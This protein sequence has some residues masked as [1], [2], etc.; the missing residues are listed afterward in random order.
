MRSN[1]LINLL[2]NFHQKSFQEHQK[3][4]INQESKVKRNLSSKERARQS[5]PMVG[6]KKDYN[7]AQV[8]KLKRNIKIPIFISRIVNLDLTSRAQLELLMNLLIN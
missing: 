6:F 2:R 5:Q 8:K 1:N 7:Q 3:T 4:N